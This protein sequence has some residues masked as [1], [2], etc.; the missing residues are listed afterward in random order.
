VANVET[1]SLDSGGLQ[2]RVSLV[3]ARQTL[4]A[5]GAGESGKGWNDARLR[6][7]RV[8]NGLLSQR[9]CVGPKYLPET[10]HNHA[11]V[12]Q[13]PQIS[14]GD[15]RGRLQGLGGWR[16]LCGCHLG[17]GKLLV[18]WW[19]T[20]DGVGRLGHFRWCRGGLSTRRRYCEWQQGP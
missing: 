2:N 10:A 4:L 6:G 11:P 18:A 14:L 7:L 13:L 20:E 3:A 15:L 17:F 16:G 8:P 12:H 1:V 19:M 9:P 5:L